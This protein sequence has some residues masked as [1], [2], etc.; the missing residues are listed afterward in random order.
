MYDA[1]KQHAIESILSIWDFPTQIL[2]LKFDFFWIRTRDLFSNKK[3]FQS[4]ANCPLADS[5][6]FIVYKFEHV[7]GGSLYSAVQVEQ[8]WTC[9]R[10]WDPVQGA[11]PCTQ[12]W[13]QGPVHRERVGPGPRTQGKGG[14]RPCMVGQN[15]W[16]TD[17][18][19]WKHNLRYSVGG[20]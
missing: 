11:G 9:W 13:G 6:C 2:S 1:I 12:G 20:Q 4:N 8:V 10:G 19:D 15:D 14:A 18:H 17:R 16:L 3:V 5:P 7:Q